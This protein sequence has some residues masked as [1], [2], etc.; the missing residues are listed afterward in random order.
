M[1]RLAPN[2]ALALASL[3]AALLLVETAL[4]LAGF[5]FDVGPARVEFGWPN[6]QQMAIYFEP[7]PELFWVPEGYRTVIDRIQREGVDLV[8]LGDSCTAVGNYP[9][10]LINLLTRA[11][12]DLDLRAL[13]LG[14]SGWTSHQGL[15]QLERDVLPARPRVVT[16]YFGWNDH[17]V[18][19]GVED[20]E[21]A[22]LQL[23]D[24]PGLAQLRTAQLFLKGRIAWRARWRAERPNRVS[25]D[26]FRAN[27]RSMARLSRAAGTVPVLITAPTSH[28][29]GQVPEYL[30][31][32]YVRD[33]EEVV[34]LH[35]QYAEI[36]REAAAAED[37]VLCDVAR[38]FRAIDP[39]VVRSDY[40]RRD[41]IHLRLAGDRAIAQ[42]LYGCF[43]GSGE[44]RAALAL[45]A[46]ASAPRA[47]D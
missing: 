19:F 26:D 41:G 21:I 29:E 7:D 9:Q 36:V 5:R 46:R 20:K 4:R 38:A 31:E 14:V 44:L 40:F 25:P 18:G 17:W 27:L 12:P 33:L 34:P 13:K 8:L 28:S 39:E 22:G 1:R 45:A 15:R 43:L 16:F 32:R 23:P 42:V 24:L 10:F 11:Q 2:L 35:R 47:P 6:P 3:L 37:A 30:A